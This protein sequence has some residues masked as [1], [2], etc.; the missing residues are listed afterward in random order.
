[1]VIERDQ[2]DIPCPACGTVLEKH[3]AADAGGGLRSRL[4]CP[5]CPKSYPWGIL[6]A[7]YLKGA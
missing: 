6:E 4:F 2:T 5:K 3:T 7:R 1:M